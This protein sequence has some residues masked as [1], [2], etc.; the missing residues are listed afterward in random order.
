MTIAGAK[1]ILPAT[2]NVW[3]QTFVT[4]QP[5]KAWVTDI[6]YVPTVEGCRY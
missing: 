3:A 2:E 1:R 6:A 5:D 4:K